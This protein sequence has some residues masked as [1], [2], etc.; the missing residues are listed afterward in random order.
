M[1]FANFPEMKRFFSENPNKRFY[2]HFEL[3]DGKTS[4]LVKGYYFKKIVPDFQ[5][6]FHK[7]GDRM[8]LQ[9]VDETLRSWYPYARVE[10]FKN[11]G[12]ETERIKTIDEFT[13]KEMSD[14]IEHLRMIAGNEFDM[15]I[16]DP[17]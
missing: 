13:N 14:F 11:K 5:K 1:K 8:S 7:V 2:L 12:F 6:V 16:E 10:V 4:E 9:G 17:N 3:I 15:V